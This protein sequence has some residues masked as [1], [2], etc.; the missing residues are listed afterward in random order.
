M[1]RRGQPPFQVTGSQRRGFHVLK[2]LRRL[3][4]STDGGCRPPQG[5]V[6]LGRD[7]ARQAAGHFQ[8][9]ARETALARVVLRQQ[10][11]DQVERGHGRREDRDKARQQRW[12]GLGQTALR[13]HEGGKVRQ[14]L[15]AVRAGGDVDCL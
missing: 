10:V 4:L 15:E 11:A 8:G 6:H 2:G 5:Q 12:Q 9:S 7:V 13:V 14:P 3:G 1:R